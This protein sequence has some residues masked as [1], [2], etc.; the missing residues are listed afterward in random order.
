MIISIIFLTLLRPGGFGDFRKKKHLNA[1]GFAQEL[2]RF[3]RFYRLSEGLKK[4]SK[5]S[6]LHSKKKFLREGWAFCE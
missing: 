3:G 4:R 1:R 5:S 6:R 2:L